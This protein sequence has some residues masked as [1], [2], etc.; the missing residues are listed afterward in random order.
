MSPKTGE[1]YLLTASTFSF[2]FRHNDFEYDTAENTGWFLFMSGGPVFL[3][4]GRC[5]IPQGGAELAGA[6]E[7]NG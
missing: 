7:S 2:Q 4:L 1:H 5:M 3:P 6:E